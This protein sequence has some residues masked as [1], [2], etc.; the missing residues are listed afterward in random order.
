MEM[1][2]LC[3]LPYVHDSH[4]CILFI[5]EDPVLSIAPNLD[6]RRKR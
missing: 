1:G 6:D 3:R 5:E 4:F 2:T